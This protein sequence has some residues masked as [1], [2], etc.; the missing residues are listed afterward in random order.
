MI[1][2]NDMVM[3]FLQDDI[4]LMPRLYFVD[5]RLFEDGQNKILGIHFNSTI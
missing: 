5:F 4:I 1:Y 2:H 3:Y